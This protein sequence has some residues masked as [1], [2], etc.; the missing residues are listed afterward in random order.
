M[1]F[2]FIFVW[3]VLIEPGRLNLRRISLDHWQGPPLKI[4]FFSD[5]HAGA[6][7]IDQE[8]IRNLVR[9]INET[10]PDLILITGDLVI[11][12][13]LGGERIPISQVAAILKDL[14]APLGVYSVLGNH[15]WSNNGH[16]I[17][18]T[19]A[20]QGILPLENSAKLIEVDSQFKFW[21]V[22]IGDVYTN[23]ADAKLALAQVT[24]DDPQI[25]FMHDPSVVLHLEQKFFLALAGH[26]HGGQ[27]AIPGYGALITPGYAPQQWAS[28]WGQSNLG[29]VVVT[30]GIGTSII[31][32]R[33]ASTPE[34]VVL[35]LKG[36]SSA[37]LSAQEAP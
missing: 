13:V 27:I 9:R 16:E 24:S 19:L 11:D 29:T 22:G 34:F 23:H 8:Y 36:Q 18:R 37:H 31:P 17:I 26:L 28:G 14:R 32:M 25:L 15:D 10:S 1:L 3:G 4:A 12:G 30:K 35:E 6:P 7:H 2:L 5:L 33:I 20:A 21:L